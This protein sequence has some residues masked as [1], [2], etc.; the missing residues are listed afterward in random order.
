MDIHDLLRVNQF[1]NYRKKDRHHKGNKQLLDKLF[2]RDVWLIHIID[3]Q[4]DGKQNLNRY[5][6]KPFIV[7]CALG[8]DTFDCHYEAEAHKAIAVNK[9]V[10]FV[11]KVI[12]HLWKD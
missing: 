11:V 5:Q 7:Y 1:Y 6:S 12:P 2:K 9:F 3:P 4:Q 8:H 10:A